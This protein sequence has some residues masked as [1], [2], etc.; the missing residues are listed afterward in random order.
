MGGVAKVLNIISGLEVKRFKSDHH[1]VPAF[2]HCWIGDSVVD[3][4][5][6]GDS[7][8]VPT[9]Y[10]LRGNI[11]CHSSQVNFLEMINA[12]ENEEYSR[13]FSSSCPQAA[14]PEDDCSFIFLYNLKHSVK[15]KLWLVKADS[16]L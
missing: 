6:H 10:L 5:V 16:L 4:G 1:Q 12:G 9:Q 3:D 14:Q 2:Y 15:V 11:K 7:D 8:T 13:A